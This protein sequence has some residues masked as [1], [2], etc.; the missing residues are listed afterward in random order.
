M[1]SKQKL[2]NGVEIPQ[3]GLGLWKNVLP[4]VVNKSVKSALDAGYTHFDS[5]Q[6]YLNEGFLGKALAK[7]GTK[8]EEVFITTK[9]WNGNQPDGKLQKSILKS[10]KKLD[11]DYIDLLLLHFP[12]TK[13]RAR[14]W[15]LL[16]EAYEKKQARAIGV[17]NY[18]VRHL[19]ELLKTCKVKPMVNQVELHVFLQQP[20][21][22][23]YCKENGI[24]VEAY[25]PIA[26]GNGL[27]DPALVEIAKKHSKSTAQIMIRWCIEVGAVPLPKSTHEERIKQNIDVFDFKLD[28][29]DMKKLKGLDKNLRTCWDPTDVE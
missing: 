22:L 21:L 3:I 24:V 2:S 29:S 26:H 27:D 4:N 11:T 10:L 20:E 19:E 5:A 9:V 8:R 15:E 23:A 17:S 13:T 18:T 25:S 12:V 28:S 16:E 7:S 14:A 6:I 1:V